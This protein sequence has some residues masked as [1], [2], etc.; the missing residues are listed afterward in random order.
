MYVLKFK[1]CLGVMPRVPFKRKGKG[2]DGRG[3]IRRGRGDKG[4]KEGMGRE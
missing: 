1:N 4:I 2:R 3:W